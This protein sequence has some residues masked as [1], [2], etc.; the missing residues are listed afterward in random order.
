MLELD[1]ART[2]YR[3]SDFL[4]W[5]RARTLVLSPSFQRR[6]VWPLAAKSY[7]VDTVVRGLP[8]PIIFLREKTDLATLGPKR[9]FV[10]GQQRLG[11]LLA[12]IEPASLPDFDPRID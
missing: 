4:S 5:Q 6:P 9:K 1:L 12:F 11:T 3:V 8:V 7:L 2:L 10:D